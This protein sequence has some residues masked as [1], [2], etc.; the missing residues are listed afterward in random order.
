MMK[1]HSQDYIVAYDKK[2]IIGVS[3]NQSHEVFQSRRLFYLVAEKE[4]RDW[5]HE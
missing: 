1:Y 3:L 2:K 5:Q 4:D